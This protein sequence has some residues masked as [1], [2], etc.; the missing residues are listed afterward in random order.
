MKGKTFTLISFII[1]IA[2]N[3]CAQPGSLDPTFSKDGRRVTVVDSLITGEALAIQKDGK[4]V[5]A[6]TAFNPP[7]SNSAQ[8]II[9]RYKPDGGY[10]RSFGDSGIV[11]TELKAAPR[12]VIIQPDGKIVVGAN[13]SKKIA[14]K[15]YRNF[16]A[17]L[18]YHPNGIIDSTFG[19]NGLVLTDFQ[20]KDGGTL[21]S[22]ILQPDGKFVTGG[23]VFLDSAGYYWKSAF[24]LAR[25]TSDGKLDSS[26]GNNGKVITQVLTNF[27]FYLTER[28][29]ALAVQDDGKI[30]AGGISN[31]TFSSVAL[32]RYYSNGSV[33]SSF[34]NSGRVRL[35]AYGWAEGNDV[36]LKRN[37]KIVVGG[38]VSPIGNNSFALFQF[39]SN[40]TP[41]SNFAVNGVDSFHILIAQHNSTHIA[42]QHDGKIVIAG[43]ANKP[44]DNNSVIVLARVHGNGKLDS[45]FGTHGEVTTEYENFH[46]TAQAVALQADGKIVTAGTIWRYIEHPKKFAEKIAVERYNVREMHHDFVNN[47]SG[48]KLKDLFSVP[49]VSPNPTK[50]ILH[51]Q[52]LS[53]SAKTISVVD[54]NGKVLQ[55]T[56]TANNSYSFNIKHFSAGIYFVRIDDDKK[57]SVLKFVKE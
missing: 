5:V 55:Q 45:R 31:S 26:F 41:D 37:G 9:V 13:F 11:I 51:L 7:S 29:N 15:T 19:E 3:V 49:F 34:G 56:V 16:F 54:V 14:K 57:S 22:L 10:D 17:V 32:V 8:L 30:I 4:I 24:A 20:Q 18:R 52:N 43:T 28:C 25:F 44:Y 6:G 42:L 36:L 27:N 50:D 33:D 48:N 1:L 2:L 12:S 40:G 39:K 21:T 23:Y 35:N 47:A 46:A 53:S 38:L